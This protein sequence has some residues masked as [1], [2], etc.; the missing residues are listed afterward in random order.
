MAA[1]GRWRPFLDA[2]M[3][4]GVALGMRSDAPVIA[5]SGTR[6]TSAVPFQAVFEQRH[7]G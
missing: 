5:P 1:S 6:M 2:L 7:P 4:L 3:P